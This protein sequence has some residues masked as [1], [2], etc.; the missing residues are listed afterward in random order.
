[1]SLYFSEEMEVETMSVGWK[2][3]YFWGK[4]GG[5]MQLINSIDESGQR[6]KIKVA[7]RIGAESARS[8]IQHAI[9][10]AYGNTYRELVLDLRQAWFDST[11]QIFR[12]HSLLQMFKKVI[13]QKEMRITVLF[14][15]DEG[16][17]WMHLVKADDFDGIT[18]RY[19]TNREAALHFLDQGQDWTPSIH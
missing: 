9:V 15:L 3:Q 18:L 13:M 5:A 1:M 8:I 4:K 12:L 11:D 7:G 17:Q 10:E 6:I 2:D 19:F 16:E 14:S